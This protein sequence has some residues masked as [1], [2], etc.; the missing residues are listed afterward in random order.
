MTQRTEG[1]SPDH[2][3]TAA[4]TIT[5]N[6]LSFRFV[7][8]NTSEQPAPPILQL[9]ASISATGVT[10]IFGR[11]GAG[12]TTLLRCIAGLMKPNEGH[13]CF[14]RNTWQDDTNFIAP[15]KRPIGYVFQDANLFAHLTAEGN[16]NFAK[17]RAEETISKAQQEKIIRTFELAPLLKR[18]P[19]Q[20]SGGE[21]QRVA[22]ARALFINPKLI[23]MDEPLASLDR[24][25]KQEILPYLEKLHSEFNLPILYVTHSVDEVARLADHILVLEKGR[26][27]AQ[28]K[29]EELLTDI[30]N[31]MTLSD[32]TCTVLR[33]Q[34]IE[35]DSK[36]NLMKLS[37]NGGELW[38]TNDGERTQLG[39]SLRVRLHARDISL[40]LT[41]QTDSSILNRLPAAVLNL[42]S[43]SDTT[44][45]TVQLQVGDQVILARVTQRSAHHLAL[46][47]GL[48]LWAQIK[49]VAFID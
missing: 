2:T 8:P 19:N 35:I 15:H 12:K 37:F 47:P 25:L 1:L 26:L 4:T 36:W 23:L 30:H 21:K 44:M 11:S 7:V 27:A 28:G 42:T 13:L 3:S 34:K 46:K 40:A 43:D 41:P 6:E 39:D 29:L 10:A 14:Q 16:L 33:T 38:V 5:P 9:E 24:Q 18:Y 32:D 45:T 22:I 20:L 17:K 49:S 31:P 48:Q